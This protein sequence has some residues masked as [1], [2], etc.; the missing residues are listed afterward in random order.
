MLVEIILFI[1]LS[2]GLLLTIPP[3]S[4]RG[5]FMSGK[6]S[7]V[8]I[9]IH[10]IVFGVALYFLQGAYAYEGFQTTGTTP[11]GTTPPGTTP[12]GTTPPGT[13]PP[14]PSGSPLTAKQIQN[15]SQLGSQAGIALAELI[16]GGTEA[17]IGK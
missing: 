14:G 8:A 2:P 16:V 5:L 1:L 7:T 6:T 13:T 11:P 9:L 4:K 12:P 10:A 3:V 17:A 15:A